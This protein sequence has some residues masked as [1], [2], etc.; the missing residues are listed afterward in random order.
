MIRNLLF[1]IILFFSFS[2]MLMGL[3]AQ[4]IVS[5]QIFYRTYQQNMWEEGEAY[6]IDFN[7]DLFNI[8]Q[9][10]NN[11]LGDIS[12][13]L[14][15]QFGAL[16][17]IDWWL[18][19]ASHIAYNGFNGGEVDI[20]YPVKIDLEFPDNQEFNQGDIVT[21]HSHYDV[22]DGWLMNTRFPVEGI[23]EFGFDFGFG[24]DANA[25]ICFFDCFDLPIMNY[26]IPAESHNIIDINTFTGIAHYPC[27]VNNQLQIC[28]TQV[29]PIVFENLA[30]IGLSGTISIP[31]VETEAYI[32]PNTKILHAY[33]DSAYM[34][35]ELNIIQFLMALSGP[36]SGVYEVLS[37]LQGQIE[38]GAGINLNYNLLDIIFS[39]KNYLVQDFKFDP[40]IWTKVSFPVAVEYTETDPQN[41]HEV[42]REGFASTIFFAVDNDLNFKYPCN[43]YPDMTL[44]LA[45]VMTNQFTNKTWDS[46]T[47]NLIIKAL[48]FTLELP[49]FPSL[50]ASNIPELC[51]QMPV[52]DVMTEFCQG[53]FEIPEI[54]I[55][56]LDLSFT[57]GPLIDLTIPLGYLPMTW[58][59]RTW[60][61][62][63]F[64]P[65][66][67]G[68]IFPQLP[69]NFDTLIDPISIMPNPPIELVLSGTTV[70]CYGDSTGA[71]I[72]TA[73]NATP[74]YTFT[75]S[76]GDVHITNDFSD[77]LFLV[78]AGD[79]GVTVTD[80]NGCMDFKEI[81]I[82]QNS[83]IF[84]QMSKTD[85]WC[86]GDPSG[87][88][89][90]LV[91]GGTPGYFYQWLPYGS[92]GPVNSGIYA[93]EYTVIITDFLGCKQ[94]DTISLFELNPKAPVDISF[95][96]QEGCQPLDVLFAE[97]N[98]GDTN[99]YLWDFGDGGFSDEK[100]TSY[101][102]EDA[103]SV[104]LSITV[105]TPANC[106]STRV[107]EDIITV[108][109][110]PIA[111][112]IATPE[113]VKKSEDP[114]WTVYFDENC[115]GETFYDWDFDDPSSSDNTS[116]LPSVSHSFTYEDTY[117]VRL[118]ATTEFGCVDTAY[119][120]IWIIDD[121]LGFPGVFTPNGDG[122]NDN[123]VIKN[124]EKY[125]DSH[126][127]VFNRWGN[128]M[129]EA[130][131]YRNDWDGRNAPDGTYFYILKY[132]F[133]GED[134]EYSGTFSIVR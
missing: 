36:G 132:H 115:S 22:L 84:I 35:L 45:H 108:H 121:I 41:N 40:T 38:L 52:D 56:E 94:Q 65:N 98:P 89:V 131:G 44:D 57:I 48:T 3:N 62:G 8:T 39:V 21:I 123:L 99:T 63:G 71:L 2:I 106:D 87:E 19:F 83:E 129:F 73:L 124:I 100:Q 81:D 92:D 122:V 20:Q 59:N 49:S 102:F 111:G 6:T 15:G 117:N 116:Q 97:I 64:Q 27:I 118:I 16:I 86:A 113:V 93:D 23:F 109:P 66:I 103:G 78:T 75:W 61:M 30:G 110:L 105:T 90:A 128:L 55:P 68:D 26:E 13:F 54:E 88:A 5:N 51:L 53:S 43:G 82:P 67:P 114:T 4:Q 130:V 60:Q 76:T 79:Y 95:D 17:N 133:K 91:W 10:G 34:N 32:D 33:G 18:L 7:F 42:V 31:Y 58:Y 24:V 120:L 25:T 37:N 112:F 11:S 104:S 72:A 50:S 85:V 80:A 74:P 107:Y 119:K 70:F 46:I 126:L 28:E 134:L 77:T 47:F 125:P 96:P 9:S 127:Q 101:T 1:K 69:G 14:G 29:L 12:S